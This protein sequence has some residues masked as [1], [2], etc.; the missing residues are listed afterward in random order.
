MEMTNPV[1]CVDLHAGD[2]GWRAAK[3]QIRLHACLKAK[4]QHHVGFFGL[5]LTGVTGKTGCQ[6]SLTTVNGGVKKHKTG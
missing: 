2:A 6:V 3:H 4:V 1:V 5:L